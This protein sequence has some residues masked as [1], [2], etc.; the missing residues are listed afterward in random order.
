MTLQ[1]AND[2]AAGPVIDDDLGVAVGYDVPGGRLYRYRRF[3]ANELQSLIVAGQI[4]FADASYFNDPWDCRPRILAEQPKD[5][6]DRERIIEEFK[7]T[8]AKINPEMTASLIDRTAEL[9]RSD[10]AAQQRFYDDRMRDFLPKLRRR[11]PVLCLSASAAVALMWSHYASGH[12]GVC[13]IF[14]ARTDEMSAAFKVQYAHDYPAITMPSE[15]ERD[16]LLKTMLTKPD[17]WQ[18]ETEYRVL[19]REHR[20]GDDT[21]WSPIAHNGIVTLSYD[22]FVGL[23]I[24]ASMDNAQA[25]SARDLVRSAPRPLELWR[26]ELDKDRYE[27]KLHREL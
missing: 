9:F 27:L 20:A 13:L 22:A 4:R 6:A 26:A 1:T 2:G 19:A 23:I 15:P 12:H 8:S 18:Y 3:D 10:P 7:T 14:D 24:G 16:V 25:K 11:Y 5:L 21:E 17:D